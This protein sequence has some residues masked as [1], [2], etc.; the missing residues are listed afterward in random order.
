[1]TRVAFALTLCLAALARADVPAS[2][3]E[4]HAIDKYQLL[5]RLS[6][7]LR[8]RIPSY[9]E[10]V[11]LDTETTVPDAM[12]ASWLG[13]DDFRLRMRR[14]H[15]DLFWPNVNNAAITAVQTQLQNV[16]APAALAIAST[17][18]RKVF[19]GATDVSTTALGAQCGDF[20]QT[21]FAGATGFVPDPAFVQTSVVNGVTVKQEGWRMVAPYWA[22]TTTVKV[23][24]YDAMEA[25]TVTVA[26][27][28]YHC[29]TP[30]GDARPECGCGPNL[31]FCY[32]PAAQTTL[33]FL[34][35][36]REQLLR[37]VDR[38]S[39]GGRPYTELLTSRN[40]ELNGPLA[41]WKQNLATHSNT[42]R[43]YTELDPNETTPALEFTDATWHAVDRGSDLHAGVLTS[44]GYLFRF[45]TNRGR[46]NR[47]RI[48]FEC[49]SFVP[50]SQLESPSAGCSENGMDLTKRCTCR[51]CHRQLE[52]LAA[53]WGQFAEAGSTLMSS[54]TEFPRVNPACVGS[55]SALCRRFYVTA[56]DGDNK[57]SLLAW[58]YADAQHQ[59]ILDAINHGPTKRVAEIV[60]SGT[61]A[62][63]TVKR[64][65][66]YL[67]KRDMR[68]AGSETDELA[69]LDTLANGFKT[70]GYSLPWLFHEIVKTPSYR[71]NR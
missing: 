30:E 67:L 50:P 8:G 70:H 40:T 26:G 52:P 22:P 51:Y 14:Y 4:P 1:M 57:G 42:G 65:W 63:C 2:C 46:G 61:L 10:Y 38:V 43:L 34:G 64:A 29:N 45:Q 47:F 49:E 56:A 3:D 44:P 59:E 7:D 28:T 62:R 31:R 25:T 39:T 53:H 48:D 20:E 27:K 19:R 33:V 11:A 37:Q 13:T 6:L 60:A 66:N 55:T 23:C 21:H 15:E 68:V 18:K 12:V 16:M 24:A 54:T 71:S 17:G 35:A 36:M 5:R 41:F 69:T 9:E 32:G 58:Q